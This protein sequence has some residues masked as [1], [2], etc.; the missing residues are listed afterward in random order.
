M[1][2]RIEE[3][4]ALTPSENDVIKLMCDGKSNADIAD[5]LGISLSTVKFHVSNIFMKLNAKNRHEAIKIAAE[6]G[7]I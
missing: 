2:R 5:F 1:H 7:I 6:L 3:I 4:P